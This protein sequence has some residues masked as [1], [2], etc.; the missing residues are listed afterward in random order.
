MKPKPRENFTFPRVSD[1]WLVFAASAPH[2]SAGF[3]TDW[4]NDH[5]PGFIMS[6]GRAVKWGDVAELFSKLADVCDGISDGGDFADELTNL[7]R[8]RGMTDE[9][10]ETVLTFDAEWQA[11][12]AAFVAAMKQVDAERVASG[13]P[14]RPTIRQLLTP[15]QQQD[16]ID[17]GRGHLLG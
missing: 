15:A 13:Y 1:D 9:T 10:V 16:L 14:V 17:A 4:L 2:K 5:A 12:R 8:R 11:A 6:I 7:V 3:D